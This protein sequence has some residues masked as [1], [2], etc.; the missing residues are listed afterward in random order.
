MDRP[1]ELEPASEETSPIQE[2]DDGPRKSF[3]P[4]KFWN[5]LTLLMVVGIAGF[6]LF[7]GM[8]YLDP[9]GAFNPFP[10]PTMVPTL[11]LPSITPLP[12]ATETPF[13]LPPT[14]TATSIPT[15]TTT[16]IPPTPTAI[17]ATPIGTLALSSG[18]PETPTVK[19]TSAFAFA[20][21]GPPS[22]IDATLLDATHGCNWMGVGGRVYDLQN[23]P[24]T[25]IEVKLF[26]V[27]NGNL[28]N[29]TGLTG[30][31][32]QYGPSG[33]EF[34]LANKTI[35]SSQRLWIQLVDQAGVPLSDRIFFD[36]YSEC[37]KNLI[38]INFKQVR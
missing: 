12:T 33:F 18:T 3:I 24:A 30:T 14:F 8:I 13:H 23:A 20:L 34:T 1:P 25:K 4:D 6:C 35:A 38:V 5:V 32:L 19:V 16:P 9:N 17:Q 26:G 7:Y 31:A 10:V 28:L 27:L 15:P 36:T 22:A 2:P 37:S 11:F 21:Q 29:Q